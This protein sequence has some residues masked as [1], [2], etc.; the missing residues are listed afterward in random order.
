[1]TTDRLNVYYSR[2]KKKPSEAENRLANLYLEIRTRI[3]LLDYL[4][5]AR[6]NEANLCEEFRVSRTPIRRV[7]TRLESEGLIEIHHGDG[8]YVTDLEPTLLDEVYALRS[9]LA[10]LIGVLSPLTPTEET[11]DRLKRICEQIGHLGEEPD[12]KRFGRLN[13][14]FHLE[15]TNL[16]GNRPLREVFQKLFFQTSRMWLME[17]PRLDWTIVMNTV[18]DDFSSVIAALERSDMESLGLLI[19]LNIR[20]MRHLLTHI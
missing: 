16:I 15:I 14:E 5:G 4:P 11:I 6:I 7:L 19:S 1:M 17:L 13:T 3:I 12:L 20:N 18:C 8:T 2:N 10:P 9:H